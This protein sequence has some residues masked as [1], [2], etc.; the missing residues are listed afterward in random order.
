MSIRGLSIL[1]ELSSD[2]KKKF[3]WSSIKNKI[4]VRFFS[5]HIFFSWCKKK[6]L[7]KK[8]QKN[9]GIRNHFCGS[10]TGTF[11]WTI[12]GLDQTSADFFSQQDDFTKTNRQFLGSRLS[13]FKKAG[14]LQAK[15]R[16]FFNIHLRYKQRNASTAGMLVFSAVEIFR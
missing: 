13:F 14:C 10:M 11:F 7:V 6:D 16:I 3:P 8:W 12:F 2:A 9:L 1:I 15:Y 5:Q 4:T